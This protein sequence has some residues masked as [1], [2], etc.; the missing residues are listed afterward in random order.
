VRTEL[1][2]RCI[3]ELEA[4]QIL[5]GSGKRSPERID[6]S[7]AVRDKQMHETLKQN[8]VCNRSERQNKVYKRL[9]LQRH[10]WNLYLS[11]SL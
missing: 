3:S 6:L 9:S 11:I 1:K 8:E 4:L 5:T 2:Y 7:P 10:W